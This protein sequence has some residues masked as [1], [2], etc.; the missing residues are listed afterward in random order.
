MITFTNNSPINIELVA[1]TDEE[2]LISPGQHVSVQFH[3]PSATLIVRVSDDLLPG[4]ERVA[5]KRDILGAE[6][7]I[8]LVPVQKQPQPETPVED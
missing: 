5:I 1:S 7:D 4:I 3:A 6:G 8:Q 2:Q